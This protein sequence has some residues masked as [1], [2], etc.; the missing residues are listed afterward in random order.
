MSEGA[1]LDKRSLFGVAQG[2]PTS[3][4]L[5]ILAL[6]TFLQQ[7]NSLSY[8]DDPI[9]WGDHDFQI[10]DD[11]FQGI[12]L[13]KEKSGWIKR[14]GIW[15]KT[16]RYLGLEYNPS[17]GEL[18]SLRKK[19]DNRPKLTITQKYLNKILQAHNKSINGLS[20]EKKWYKALKNP[21]MGGF[22]ISRLYLGSLENPTYNVNTSEIK[23][24]SW[25]YNTR[26]VNRNLYNNSSKAHE[27]LPHLLRGERH[28]KY[29][30]AVIL[31]LG[32]NTLLERMG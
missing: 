5:S 15:K 14:N 28:I 19:G 21:H 18:S 24:Q 27:Y 29:D 26:A 1:V 7:Q 3:P 16:L 2:S 8:A 6:K 31:E 4:L 12:K 32:I 13:N 17:N 23:F 11:E 9:F 30:K 25:A 10:E 20:F 22:L